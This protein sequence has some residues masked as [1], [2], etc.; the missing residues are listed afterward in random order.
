MASQKAIGFVGV[1]EFSLEMAHS[2][3]RRGYGV[4]A[5]E[6]NNPVIEEI[7]KL[8]GV[9]CSSPSEAGRDVTAL[10][11]LISHI[12]QTNDLIFGDEGALKGLKPDTVLILRS[13]LL[14]SFL[15]KLEKD[16]AEIHEIAYVVDAYVSYGRSDALNG[17]VI[18]AS[19]GRLDAIARAHHILTAMCEKLFTFEGE[20]GGGSKVKMVNVMLEGIHF[21]NA[22]EALSL[23]A[24]IGIHPWIIYDIISNAAGNSWAFKNYLPLLLKG[25]VNLQILNTFI[26]E[27]V[28]LMKI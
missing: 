28:R 12:D 22:V 14:P 8:G 4:R 9:R 24:K 19:S 3:I 1:D 26:K 18:I 16:L 13:T 21:I 10:V 2:A 17:K 5:F 6:I 25:E 7:V 11:I 23:G 27:L 15:H 20:I